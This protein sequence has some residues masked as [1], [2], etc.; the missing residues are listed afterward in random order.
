MNDR[1]SRTT[2]N[3]TGFGGELYKRGGDARLVNPDI[4]T[5]EAFAAACGRGLDVLGIR[6]PVVAEY[7]ARVVDQWISESL[8]STHFWSLAEKWFVDYRL[9]HWNGQLAQSKPGH[10]TL[11]PLASNVAFAKQLELTPRARASQRLIFEVMVRVCP[12][13]VAVGFMN[14]T[15]APD[16][17]ATSPVPVATAPFPAAQE[18]SWATMLPWQHTFVEHEEQPIKQLLDEASAET[19]IDLMLDVSRVKQ[20]IDNV[21]SLSTPEL[22][23]IIS[24]IGIACALLGQA[25]QVIDGCD[26]DP[27]A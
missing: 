24:T 25:E 10:I 4:A 23:G 12:E 14:D 17:I 3:I 11:T 15:W 2:V 18:A 26:S 22:R 6:R 7:Q 16:L 5:P 19:D 8:D 13:L 21:A 9:G 1:L 20:A 27:P